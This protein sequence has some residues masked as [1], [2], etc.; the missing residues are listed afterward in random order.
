MRLRIGGK[1]S[2]SAV[3][4]SGDGTATVSCYWRNSTCLYQIDL[5]YD[6]GKV[7]DASVL[8]STDYSEDGGWVVL[9]KKA[10][11]WAIPEKAVL[12]GGVEPPERS[13]SRK[14]SSNEGTI[15]EER[16]NL[17][18]AGNIA[19]RRAS[20]EAWDASDRQ[21][22]AFT[23]VAW[24]AAPDEES[25]A[26]L[27]QLFQ[28]F[29]ISGQ[30]NSALQKLHG[31][32]IVAMTVVSSQLMDKQLKRQ[33]FLQFLGYS[34]QLILEHGEKLA[35]MIQLRELQ[36]LISLNKIMLNAE[37]PFSV[38]VQRACEL[39]KACVTLLRTSMEYRNEYNTWYPSPEGLT[40]WYCQ[41]VARNALWSVASF[42]LHLLNDANGLEPSA[43]SELYSHLE[44]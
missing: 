11:I 17:M 2:G 36:N 37:R 32:E 38:Q 42:M 35:G 26:L 18:F 39:S 22:V 9:T 44:E 4:L 13:L 16:R 12:L 3:I 10:R 14:G 40:L 8:H 21:M 34:L 7:L 20:S 15:Q 28:S 33:K 27:G 30:V 19:P 24:R 1:P 23:G 5:P 29:L 25:E 41:P 31:A 6:A 43:K